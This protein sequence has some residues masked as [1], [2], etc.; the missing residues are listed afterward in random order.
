MLQNK[1]DQNAENISYFMKEFWQGP[2]FRDTVGEV[3]IR[4]NEKYTT[5]TE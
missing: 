2:T 5:R 1:T 4:K 3:Q